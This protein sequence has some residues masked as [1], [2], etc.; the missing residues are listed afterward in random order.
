MLYEVITDNLTS[1][2]PDHSLSGKILHFI[3]FLLILGLFLVGGYH[4]FVA[5]SFNLEDVFN[6]FILKSSREATMSPDD[7]DEILVTPLT[8]K[9]SQEEINYLLVN[10]E[11]DGSEKIKNLINKTA[12]EVNN[13]QSGNLFSYNFV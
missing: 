5:K 8:E 3:L 6:Y 2:T 1:S 4:F 11:T 9:Y 10:I 12:S 7:L 13:I